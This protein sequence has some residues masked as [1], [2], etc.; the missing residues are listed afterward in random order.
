MKSFFLHI[1]ISSYYM[2]ENA[3]LPNLLGD[4]IQQNIYW[5]KEH[6]Y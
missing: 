5:D 3:D 2:K 1:K 4:K 6:K